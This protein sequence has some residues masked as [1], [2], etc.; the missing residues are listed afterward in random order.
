MAQSR[1]Q[2]L[3]PYAIVKHTC[4]AILRTGVDLGSDRIGVLKQ[5][6]KVEIKACVRVSKTL[7]RMHIILPEDDNVFL[8][9]NSD[10]D[11]PKEGWVTVHLHQ[12]DADLF[13]FCE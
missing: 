11:L 4:G 13:R 1:S 3:P 6:A 7:E 12:Y 10:S 5:G 9:I 8:Q 2:I